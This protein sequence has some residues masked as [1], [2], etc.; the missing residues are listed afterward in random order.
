MLSSCG[1]EREQWRFACHQVCWLF[2]QPPAVAA[3]A[4]GRAGCPSEC[5]CPVRPRTASVQLGAEAARSVPR[6][7]LPGGS[8]T[9]VAALQPAARLVGAR[10]L[11]EPPSG[12]ARAAAS[13]PAGRSAPAAQLRQA[14]RPR[15]A[16]SPEVTQ[17]SVVS[18]LAV[19]RLVARARGQ[20]RAELPASRPA[21]AC[22]HSW[23]AG[24][25][26]SAACRAPAR[27]RASTGTPA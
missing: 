7:A 26:L 21:R 20:A 15:V 5:A 14:A 6:T 22:A 13:L 9:A 19:S 1:R 27:P 17:Q 4:R 3:A 23:R 16:P 24:Q 11:V 8:A 10:G 18:A 2:R 25:R 12:A